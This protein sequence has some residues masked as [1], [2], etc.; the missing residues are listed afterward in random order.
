MKNCPHIMVVDDD[1]EMLKIINRTLELEGYAVSTATDGRAA[2]ALLE[3]RSP[4]L[5][6][7]DVMMPELDGFHI[8]K[9]LRERTNV[10]VIMLTARHE[11]ILVQKALVL[12]ADD[13]I[14][15]PFR[16]IV[17]IARIR[18]KLRRVRVGAT[19]MKLPS[20]SEHQVLDKVEA[21]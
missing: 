11:P 3:E 13:Y 8:L 14:K 9:L 12:G 1:P 20:P 5:V 19:P 6:I 2:L 21:D 10:P 4:D 16:P 15:K 18:A 17:L 7:L